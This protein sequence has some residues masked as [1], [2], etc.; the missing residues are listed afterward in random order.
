MAPVTS[1]WG[2][3]KFENYQKWSR[4][5]LPSWQSPPNDQNHWFRLRLRSKRTKIAILPLFS[6]VFYSKTIGKQ[7]KL[8]EWVS[9]ERSRSEFWHKA[10][11]DSV[12]SNCKCFLETYFFD[13]KV[14][15][16]RS[17]GSDRPVCVSCWQRYLT[18]ALCKLSRFWKER[19]NFS[20]L[21]ILRLVRLF[22]YCLDF[23]KYLLLVRLLSFYDISP[24][25]S[26]Y[27]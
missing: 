12:D 25:F 23:A 4:G 27:S 13:I 8:S 22:L 19:R 3:W 20:F 18:N 7:K 16:Y 6:I 5:V 15:W 24:L 10:S 2:S 11:S 17:C 1:R 26:L 14:T 21:P 9:P